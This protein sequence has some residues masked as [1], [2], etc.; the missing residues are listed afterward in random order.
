M[1]VV[2]LCVDFCVIWF[3]VLLD[4]VFVEVFCCFIGLEWQVVGYFGKG[5]DVLI[6]FMYCL[7]VCYCGQEYGV[8]V[9]FEVVDIVEIFL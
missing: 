2:E 7:E 1:L 6:C 4:S 8:V 9:D 3:F 5:D